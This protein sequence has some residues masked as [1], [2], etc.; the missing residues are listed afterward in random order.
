MADYLAEWT[1]GRF[2]YRVHP[3]GDVER[4]G[5]AGGV[6]A[7]SGHILEQGD[8]WRQLAEW[9]RSPEAPKLPA[10]MASFSVLALGARFRYPGA[11]EVWVKLDNDGTIA[12]WPSPEDVPRLIAARWVG[13]P[14]RCLDENDDLNK[15]VEIAE[16]IPPDS[17]PVIEEAPK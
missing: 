9:I 10:A 11:P 17:A 7:W 3:N 16:P 4:G 1:R 14:V 15:V 2:C 6:K 13:Q 5:V 12:R 8:A